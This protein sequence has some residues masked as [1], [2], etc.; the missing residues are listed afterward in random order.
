MID[1]VLLTKNSFSSSPVFKECL[2]R[3]YREIPVNRLIVVDAFSS[4]ETLRFLRNYPDVEIHQIHGNRAVARQYAIKLVDTDWFMFVDDDVILCDGWFSRASK[5]VES[6]EDLGLLWGW[7]VIANRHS[8]NR[9]KI[10]YYLRRMDEYELMRRNFERRGGTHDTLVRKEA[11]EGIK[12]PSDLHVYEDWYIKG[13]VEERGFRALCP[14]DVYCFH[15]LNLSYTPHGVAQIARL[16]RKYGLQSGLVTLRNFV[17]A[18]PKSLA[19]LLVSG[20][21][22]ASSDQLRLY[23]YNFMGRF[24]W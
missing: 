5:Y 11:V 4:D 9:M 17:L 10:M 8:R 13:Y 7:D 18:V 12:I 16:Q 19:I 20:D 15:H 14:R 21:L 6:I 2:D 1:V 3:V 23:V 24:M 22:K